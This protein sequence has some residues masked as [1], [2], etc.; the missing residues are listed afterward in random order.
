MACL[1]D[2]GNW[3][4]LREMEFRQSGQKV[5]S[6]RDSAS[7]QEGE[8]AEPGAASA[9]QK[10]GLDASEKQLWNS[11]EA[12]SQAAARRGIRI[13]VRNEEDGNSSPNTTTESTTITN[14]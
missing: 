10:V 7:D 3:P 12:I 9:H 4:K 14:E 13:S 6:D 5:S 1:L 8:E 11:Q 2:A